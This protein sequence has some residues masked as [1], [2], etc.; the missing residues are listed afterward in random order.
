MRRGRISCAGHSK[1]VVSQPQ[2]RVNREAVRMRISRW[3]EVL[4][5]STPRDLRLCVPCRF[6]F[7]VCPPETFRGRQH[8][9]DALLYLEHGQCSNCPGRLL[10]AP[11]CSY[12]RG[13]CRSVEPLR[14]DPHAHPAASE[15]AIPGQG[16]SDV[17]KRRTGVHVTTCSMKAAGLADKNRITRQ[18]DASSVPPY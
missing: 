6:I 13:T 7:N 18:R 12:G 11:M 2:A 17:C 5:M 8:G 9:Y 4:L 3:T 16:W 14:H 15:L 1:S 10:L